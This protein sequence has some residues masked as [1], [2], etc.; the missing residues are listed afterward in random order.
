MFRSRGQ[1]STL[2]VVYCA[3]RLFRPLGVPK[4]P[5]RQ[6]SDDQCLVPCVLGQWSHQYCH[7]IGVRVDNG[8][9]AELFTAGETMRRHE[10][11][12]L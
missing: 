7:T 4:H 11:K 6:S 1:D 2:P 12:R 9:V 3:L 10:L 8:Q 5:S